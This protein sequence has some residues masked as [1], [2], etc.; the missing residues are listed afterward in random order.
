MEQAKKQLKISSLFVLLFAGISF[1]QIIAEL[2]FGEINSATIPEGAPD[3]ILQITKMFLLGVTII[4]LIPKFYV[5]IKGFLIVKNPTSSQRHI[6][7]AM[8]ILVFDA[9]GFI[10]PI[11][12]MVNQGNIY[13]NLVIVAN[14]S[15]EVILMYEYIKY[16]KAVSKL[17]E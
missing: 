7:L 15:L 6:I 17:A 13:D 3:N 14:V 11:L 4:L 2:V 12:N 8:I 16:A 9:I 5:G 1:I 10:D